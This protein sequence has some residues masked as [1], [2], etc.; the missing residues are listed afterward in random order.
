[1]KTFRTLQEVFSWKKEEIDGIR[2]RI[3]LAIKESE[4][5]ENMKSVLLE[6]T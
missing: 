5:H 1:M 2:E 4:A 6:A 3:A